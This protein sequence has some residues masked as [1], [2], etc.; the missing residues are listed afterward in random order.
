MLFVISMKGATTIIT[1]TSTARGKQTQ[2]KKKNDNSF[3]NSRGQVLIINNTVLMM[4]M[5]VV[6][7]PPDFFKT[8]NKIT[9][10]A[11][12]NKPQD[13][14]ERLLYCCLYTLHSSLQSVQKIEYYS[15]SIR[16]K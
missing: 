6:E 9:T 14:Y 4:M 11:T 7:K 8:Q 10:K 5:F 1:R 16:T 3:N 13:E 2:N 12:T 15:S